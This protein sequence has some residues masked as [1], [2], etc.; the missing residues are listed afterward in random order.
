MGIVSL[1]LIAYRNAEGVLAVRLY[2]LPP[3]PLPPPNNST[4]VIQWL[5]IWA[6]PAVTSSRTNVAR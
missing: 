4:D 1:T 5:K 2:V 3:P 6:S